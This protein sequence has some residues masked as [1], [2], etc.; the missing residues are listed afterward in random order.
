M[1]PGDV[2]SQIDFDVTIAYRAFTRHAR[3]AML[4]TP[5]RC[6]EEPWP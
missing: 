5:K 2:T 4:M 1:T 6:Q 3:E